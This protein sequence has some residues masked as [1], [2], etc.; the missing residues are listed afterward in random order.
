M[1][2][3]TAICDVC[4]KAHTFESNGDGFPLHIDQGKKWFDVTVVI[5]NKETLS[6]TNACSEKCGALAVEKAIPSAFDR[7]ANESF[8]RISIAARIMPL[9]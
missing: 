5:D 8:I 7:M 1:F 9:K 3:M 2:K 4:G 6:T